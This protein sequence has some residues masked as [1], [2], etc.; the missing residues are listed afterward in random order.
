MRHSLFYAE[1]ET[2]PSR[3]RCGLPGRMLQRHR[4]A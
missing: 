3:A 2:M 1:P 4:S